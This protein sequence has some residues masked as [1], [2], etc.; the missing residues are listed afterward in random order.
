MWRQQL[1]GVAGVQSGPTPD[2]DGGVTTADAV[3]I[4][5]LQDR[6]RI[7][8]LLRGYDVCQ[9]LPPWS[10]CR[11]VLKGSNA[12]SNAPRSVM[13]PDAL[14]PYLPNELRTNGATDR[15]RKPR[16]VLCSTFPCAVNQLPFKRRCRHSG[17]NCALQ[18][19]R[20][21][22]SIRKQQQQHT[23][24]LRFSDFQAGSQHL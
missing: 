7:P 18:T 14:S 24:K 8:L 11:G 12:A 19:E 10:A 4:A 1:V 9:Q 21:P 17:G 16:N 3:A 22:N 13:K 5:P 2:E 20:T 23:D 6:G 15:H